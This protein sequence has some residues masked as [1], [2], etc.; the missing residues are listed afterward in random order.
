MGEEMVMVAFGEP[1]LDETQI[2][3]HLSENLA[4]YK[5]PKTIVV[6]TEPLPKNASGKLFKRQLKDDFV[7]AK[8]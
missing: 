1:S 7:A 3:T 4:A 6:L 5:V 2:R 8:Q